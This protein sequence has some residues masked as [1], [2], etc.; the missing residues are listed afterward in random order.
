MSANFGIN[1]EYFSQKPDLKGYQTRNAASLNEAAYGLFNDDMGANGK[2]DEAV[3]QGNSGD[4]WLISGILSLS[5]TPEGKN[6]IQDAISINPDGSYNVTFSGVDKTYKITKEEL[7]AANK[8]SFLNG[9]GFSDS[10]YS[11]G[12]DDMLLIELAMEKL[13]YENDIPKRIETYKTQLYGQNRFFF[14]AVGFNTIHPE[15]HFMEKIYRQRDSKFIDALSRFRFGDETE[16]DI[17]LLDSRVISR[18]DF[19]S[20]KCVPFLTLVST[21]KEKDEINS[22]ELCNRNLIGKGVSYFADIIGDNSMETLS[23][24][25]EAITLHIGE[26]IVCT[27]NSKSYKNGTIG[28]I[29]DFTDDAIP[30]PI[31]ITSSG[32]EVTVK[33]KTIK[34]LVPVINDE[35]ISY[36]EAGSV[37]QIACQSAYAV[38]I[39][40]AQ[41]LTLDAV[42]IMLGNW[43]AE[44]SLY[45]ALSRCKTI[46]GIGLNRSIEPKDVKLDKEALKFFEQYDYQR[47]S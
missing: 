8:N 21:N 40:K 14:N 31:I 36:I 46:D 25:P 18:D 39:H 7:E 20:Q 3:F 19:A 12:D 22:K 43:A 2:I 42:Y 38:T 11:T 34:T 26:Q 28:K 24:I 41:G 6:L 4:C 17:K 27:S 1:N 10:E 16:N 37:S 5:Y 45:V 47:V 13:V 9:I 44:G 33:Q 35:C 32:K 23:Q 15:V 30:L 29:V